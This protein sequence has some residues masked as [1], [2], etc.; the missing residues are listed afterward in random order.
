MGT[1]AIK[2]LNIIISGNVRLMLLMKLS[3]MCTIRELFK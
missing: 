2:A 3:L 1:F